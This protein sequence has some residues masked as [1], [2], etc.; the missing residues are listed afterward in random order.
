MSNTVIA[1]LGGTVYVDRGRDGFDAI[2]NLATDGIVSAGHC[3]GTPGQ[4]GSIEY[5]VFIKSLHNFT[6]SYDECLYHLAPLDQL[7]LIFYI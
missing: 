3:G 2:D 1:K 6:I 4:D 5:H 7:I